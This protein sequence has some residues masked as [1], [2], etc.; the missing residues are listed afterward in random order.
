MRKT[1]CII[2]AH[3]FIHGKI[4]KRN[5]IINN[6]KGPAEDSEAIDAMEEHYDWFKKPPGG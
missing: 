2:R 6:E 4:K 1:K 3:I 5:A